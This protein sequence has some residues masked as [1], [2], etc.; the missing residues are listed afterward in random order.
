M[1]EVATSRRP[2]PLGSQPFLP[3]DAGLSKES[4]KQVHTDVAEVRVRDGELVFVLD[5][6]RMA[7]ALDGAGPTEPSESS[8]ELLP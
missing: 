1:I 4:Y 8:D 3:C 2:C 6:V 7:A 5:H